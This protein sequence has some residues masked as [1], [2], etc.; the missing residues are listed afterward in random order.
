MGI[1]GWSYPAGCESVPGDEEPELTNDEFEEKFSGDYA[2]LWSLYRSV[3]RYTSCGPNLGVTVYMMTEPPNADFDSEHCHSEEIWGH[4]T[5][6]G[7]DL[8]KL[9]SW[10][11]M[12]DQ[13]I[14]ITALHV[15]SIV[16][17]VDQCTATIVVEWTPEEKDPQELHEEFWKAVKDTDDEADRIW[18]ETHG[19]DWCREYWVETHGMELEEFDQCE[20]WEDCP[21]CEGDGVT[22]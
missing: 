22:I 6:Y 12:R 2:S 1:F 20:V 19:C 18:K 10:Q 3:Y 4:K 9:G 8:N 11:D 21:Q 16:E 13:G 15:S 5:F 14:V 17:G 7:D